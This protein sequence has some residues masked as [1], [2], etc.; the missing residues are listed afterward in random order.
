MARKSRKPERRQ[1]GVDMTL[2]RWMLSLTP[3]ERLRAVQ[4]HARSITRLRAGLTK[5]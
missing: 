3:A 1:D 4:S 2:L 5:P